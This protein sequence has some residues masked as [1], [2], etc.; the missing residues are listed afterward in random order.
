MCP[1][2]ELPDIG[3]ALAPL[4]QRVPIEQRPLLVAAAERLA[5]ERY[6]S[7][8]RSVTE[9]DRKASL[10]ACA[11]REEE[12]ARR[13]EALYPDVESLTRNILARVPE[14]TNVNRSLFAPYAIEQQFRIQAAGE[15][16]GAATWRSFAKHSTDPRT[17]EVFAGC[18]PL[19]EES[20]LVLESFLGA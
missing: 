13:V 7:W 19:E 8:A 18:A 2:P 17:A 10:L 9:P 6:R 11:D 1:P 16:L 12:I 20:A 14:L 3:Q 5:A 15:R 4:L